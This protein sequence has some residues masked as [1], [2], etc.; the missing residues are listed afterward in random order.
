[1]PIG[2]TNCKFD[3]III[4]TIIGIKFGYTNCQSMYFMI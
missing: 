1:M 3:P 4:N 2:Y